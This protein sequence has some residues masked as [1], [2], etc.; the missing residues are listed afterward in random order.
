MEIYS[1]SSW[2]IVIFIAVLLFLTSTF[3]LSLVLGN[4][5]EGMHFLLKVFCT[6]APFPGLARL[7]ASS[8]SLPTRPPILLP[9][10]EGRQRWRL[11]NDWGRDSW[12]QIQFLSSI[13][14]VFPCRV[15]F[16]NSSIKLKTPSL[17]CH[18]CLHLL[19]SPRAPNP[20]PVSFPG[21][22]VELRAL[23]W[24][25]CVIWSSYTPD[26]ASFLKF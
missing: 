22:R 13:W 6:P 20:S 21:L 12:V 26:L 10:Q 15:S 24:L 14:S 5:K 9:H 7:R 25:T 1:S 2:N 11:W 17:P 23:W 16:L 4:E 3:P 19:S 8:L 18:L